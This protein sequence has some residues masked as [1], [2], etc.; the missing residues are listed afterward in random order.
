MAVIVKCFIF[1]GVTPHILVVLQTF[2]RK[3]PGGGDRN[4]LQDVG[5][6]LSDGMALHLQKNEG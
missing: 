6:V 5:S 1:W 3:Y 4:F 2:W